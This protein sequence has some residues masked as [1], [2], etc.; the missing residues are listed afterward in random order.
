MIVQKPFLKLHCGAILA[1]IFTWQVFFSADLQAAIVFLSVPA[2][3]TASQNFGGFGPENLFDATVT[4]ADIGTDSNTF[5]PNTAFASNSINASPVVYMTF[6]SVISADSFAF[7]Q[8]Q[9]GGVGSDKVASLQFWFESSLPTSPNVPLRTADETIA[10][11]DT[12]N[13]LSQLPF[14]QYVFSA[15]HSAQ[16]VVMRVN[17][18]FGGRPGGNEF[19]LSHGALVAVPE[20]STLTLCGFSLVGILTAAR[21]KYLV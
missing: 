16:H 9:G 2:T 21:R 12:G 14:R 17:S 11:L 8:R 4:P 13:G 18:A 1:G 15:E 3:V 5:S 20:P 19:R 6:G 10:L 7:A